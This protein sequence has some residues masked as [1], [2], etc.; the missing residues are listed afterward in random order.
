MLI[1]RIVDIIFFNP[2]AFVPAADFKPFEI[3]EYV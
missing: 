1:S 3:R 2:K